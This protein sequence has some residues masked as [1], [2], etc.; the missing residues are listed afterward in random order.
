LDA[1][2]AEQLPHAR[3]GFP[4]EL[5]D[6]APCGFIAF[7]DDATVRFVNATLL[8]RL[9]FTAAEIVDRHVETIFTVPGRIFFQTHFF[10]LVMLHGG[11]QEVFVLL[12][13]KDG[14]AVGMLCNAVRQDRS[15]SPITECVFMEVRERRKYEDA[16]LVAKREA[17]RAN[18]TLEEQ[19]LELEMQH[20]QLQDQATELERQRVE[21]EEARSVAAS[22]NR[23]KSEFLAVMSHE[24][25][26]PLNAIGGYT[27]LLETEI[28]GPVTT[29]QGEAL[30]RIVR[31]QRH[32]LG[33]INDV[34]N[35]ARVETG[36]VD[37]TI[38]DVPLAEV[39]GELATMIEPQMTAKDLTY[40]VEQP[41]GQVTVR[42]D[43][44]KLVQI[45]LNLLSNAV[46]FTA[47]GGRITLRCTSDAAA[48]QMVALM[49]EDTGRGIPADKIESVFEPFVQVRASGFGASE[50]TGLGLAISRNLARG[51]GGDLTATSRVGV[52]SEFVLT[53][54][55]ATE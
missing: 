44:E 27:Q 45:L 21:A 38:T 19:A 15:G 13:T 7:G 33:L 35:L 41:D 31:S 3:S 11:A 28:Y 2:G 17:E 16:L 42:A 36:R 50:G 39:I 40:A 32:L 22:A 6:R 43:R 5:L 46:K 9:G 20:Q 1:K 53:L 23:A 29:E 8:D 37:Y 14:D 55:R 12:R 30:R 4:G 25:R 49:V 48:P 18:R 52:G 47:A 34:L 54:P 51:M 26:T 10:P 24:L